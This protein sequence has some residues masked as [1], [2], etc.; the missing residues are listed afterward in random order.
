MEKM[1]Y[2]V[3]KQEKESSADF[4][5]KMLGEVSPKLV[6]PGVHK[7]RVSI[8]DEDVAP[9]EP[10]RI[11]ATRPAAEGI[12][13][14]W[15]DTA[16]NRS[17]LEE[18]IESAVARMVGYLVT[19]SVP[20]VNTKHTVRDGERVPGMNS[21]V[22][23]QKPPRLSYEYWL[24][25]WLGSHT[26]IGIDTQSTFGYKQNVI[27]RP[28]TYVAPPYD[29]IVEENFPEEAMT[30]NQ[31]FYNAKGD[32]E[33]CSKNEQAMIESCTRFIDF[34]KLDR[35]LTSEYVVKS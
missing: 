28:L 8:V 23:L 26:Q 1:I 24:E 29:A 20:I 16:N 7:L 19:E 2:A 27:V 30:D 15:V 35:I 4:R 14:M 25:T 5:E 34:D 12:I 10:L 11:I 6:K 18:V 9:A 22:F 3:W 21:V 13:S 31:V 32:E 33:K 17:P